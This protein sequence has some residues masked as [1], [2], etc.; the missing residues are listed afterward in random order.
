MSRAETTGAALTR[1][2]V[3]T[4]TGAA[5]FA[6]AACATSPSGGAATT[7]GAAPATGAPAAGAPLA[8]TEDIP[9]GGG[10]IFPAAH[11][12]VTQPAPAQF[13][14]FSSTCTHMGCTVA[15]V[16]DGTINCPCHGSRFS[17]SDGSPTHGPAQQPL[18]PEQITVRGDTITLA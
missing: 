17:I 12:V 8:R 15:Q 1:R 3:L 6:L 14:A 7:T 9:L 18:P 10:K 4:G 16:A 2:T 13:K 11:V 5:V